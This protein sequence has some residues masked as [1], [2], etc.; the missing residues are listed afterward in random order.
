MHQILEKVL[1]TDI[2]HPGACHLYI[3]ATEST[4]KPEKALDCARLL[5]NAIPGMIRVNHMPSTPIMVRFMWK[6]AVKAN[7]QAWQSDQKAEYGE[8]FE[9]YAGHNLHM[10]LFAASMDGQGAIA[11]QAGKDH[12]VTEAPFIGNY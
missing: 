11:M 7:I 1:T 8:G 5:G 4:E 2:T 9:I 10:L 6:E 3:H 12:K